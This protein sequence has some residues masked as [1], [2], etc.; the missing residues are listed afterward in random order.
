MKPKSFPWISDNDNDVI[1]AYFTDPA[2]ICS[3]SRPSSSYLGDRLLIQTGPK[4]SNNMAIPFKEED[5]AGTKWVKGQCF[6]SMG[7]YCV[8]W[9]VRLLV[10]LFQ[11]YKLLQLL[12]REAS[13]E[14][15]ARAAT[16]AATKSAATVAARATTTTT[17]TTTTK[18]ATAATTA[19]ATV[20]QQQC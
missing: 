6:Y 12:L 11:F 5:L 2:G 8:Y 1:T 15:A 9:V 20:Q 7:T 3:G 16:T 14:E 18:T 17:T 19:S 10:S 4:P 13:T